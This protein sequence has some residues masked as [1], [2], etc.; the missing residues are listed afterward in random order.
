MTVRILVGDV[1]EKNGR[2]RKGVHAYR[3]PQPH[4]DRDWLVREYIDRHRSAADIAREVGCTENNILFWLKKHDIPRRSISAARAIKRWGA[5]GSANPMFGKTGHLNPR[6]VDGSAPERQRLY[7][8]AI[9]RAFLKRIYERDGYQCVRCGAPKKG[10]R[11]LH[12]HH[13][14]PWAGNPELRFD[15]SN[16]ITLCRRCHHWVHSKANVGREFLA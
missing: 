8:R 10:R 6:Y 11:S 13:I 16:A 7:V 4:W 5:V 12:V 2:F 1:R 3:T 15:E 9:G 14:K